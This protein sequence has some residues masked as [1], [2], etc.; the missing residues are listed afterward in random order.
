MDTQT[1]DSQEE[2]VVDIT[3]RAGEDNEDKTLNKTNYGELG[4]IQKNG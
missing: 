1:Q 2:E 4:L 3:V